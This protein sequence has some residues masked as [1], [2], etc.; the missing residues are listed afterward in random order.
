MKI[1]QLKNVVSTDSGYVFERS[2]GEV[3]FRVEE[4]E[5]SANSQFFAFDFENFQDFSARIEIH[6]YRKLTEKPDFSITTGILPKIAT[7]VE[8]PL[9]YLDGQQLFGERRKG[10]LK[11]VVNGTRMNTAD[12][13][14]VGIFMAKCHLQPVLKIES[15]RF[16]AEAAAEDDFSFDRLIDEFGQRADKD[17]VGKTHDLTELSAYLNDELYLAREY[18]SQ[19]PEENFGGTGAATFAATGFYRVEKE[20]EPADNFNEEKVRWRMITPDGKEFFGFGCDV[21]EPRVTGATDEEEYALTNLS[22]VWGEHAYENWCLLTKYRLAKWGI[23]TVAAWSDLDFARQYKLPYVTI[24]EWYPHTKQKIYRDFPDVFSAD[25]QKS[26]EQYAQELTAFKDDPYLIGY[27]MSNEPNWAFSWGLKLGYETF[28]ASAELTS[29]QVL[30]DWLS[31]HYDTIKA[32]NKDFG[33]R[34]TN[35]TEI[36][37]ADHSVKI[38]KKGLKVLKK[39]QKVLINE[40]IRV[41][42]QALRKVD[43]QHLNLGIR[44]AFI[45]DDSLYEGAEYL[46]IFSINSYDNSPAKNIE[47]VFSH[48]E[49]PVMIGEFH[50]GALDR[51]LP[52]TGICAAIDQKNRGKAIS[53]YLTAAKETGH[54][55]GAHYFQLNDQPYLGRFDGENYNIGLVDVCNREYTEVTAVMQPVERIPEVFF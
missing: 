31:Q 46:D 1:E 7:T 48:T 38:K 44:Y 23:N 45:S 12:I 6:F 53:Y 41:P 49:K 8:I 54:C 16:T 47:K 27:F 4:G 26:A 36:L 22:K 33:T 35:F 21:V 2:G 32:L 5:I 55:V 34:F 43:S 30:I 52:A 11:T 40:F 3:I 19:H 9:S 10:I 17:W 15:P 13:Q 39:F 50:F 51:G 14:F 24:F 42:A 28:C 29:K 37:S 25:F 18:L 20:V